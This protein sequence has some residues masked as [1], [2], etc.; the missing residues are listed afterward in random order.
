MTSNAWS[1]NLSVPCALGISSC[2]SRYALMASSSGAG[3]SL[4]KARNTAYIKNSLGSIFIRISHLFRCIHTSPYLGLLLTPMPCLQ[5]SLLFSHRLQDLP[6]LGDPWDKGL[7]SFRFERC[8]A[9]GIIIL[10]R[11]EGAGDLPG[12]RTVGVTVGG[13]ATMA[14]AGAGPKDA[15]ALRRH[16]A[17]RAQ[18]CQGG[19]GDRA[20]VI[21]AR[22]DAVHHITLTV[23]VGGRAFL[24]KGGEGQ[25]LTGLDPSLFQEMVGQQPRDRKSTRLNSS[26]GYISYAVF[27]LKKK[28]KTKKREV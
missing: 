19:A 16:Q 6:P 23:R 4:L 11:H 14:V 10:H 1:S 24:T 25:V 27:C 8:F 22:H 3:R 2:A 15:H 20:R 7:T 26:H 13:K 9:Q 5:Q 28:K 17:G 21:L 12:Q 18:A